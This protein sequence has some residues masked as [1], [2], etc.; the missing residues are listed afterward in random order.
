MYVCVCR[1]VTDGKIC[2]AVTHGARTMRD[3]NQLLGV[4]SQCGK[5]GSCAKQVLASALSGQGRQTR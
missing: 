4:A 1:S 2:Q 5:C 3:L